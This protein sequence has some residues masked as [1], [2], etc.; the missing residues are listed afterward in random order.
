MTTYIK[1]D[2]IDTDRCHRIGL[3]DK[4][5]NKARL[6]I[7][8][9]ARCSVRGKVFQ[10]NLKLKDAGKSITESLK[11]K[12]IGQLNDGRGKYGFNVWS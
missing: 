6:I 9:F 3:Y 10:E 4:A 2:G 7:V 8:K 12:R 5:K 11:A 1:I